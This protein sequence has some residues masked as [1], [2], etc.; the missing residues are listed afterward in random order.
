MINRALKKDL[1]RQQVLEFVN[2]SLKTLNDNQAKALD[3][4]MVELNE[5]ASN[6]RK[7]YFREGSTLNKYQ[8]DLPYIQKT[9]GDYISG[10]K[11]IAS[12]A[13]KM[14][15]D[16][17]HENSYSTLSLAD[18]ATIL[19]SI[20]QLSKEDSNYLLKDVLE[21]DTAL[22]IHITDNIIADMQSKEVDPT[23]VEYHLRELR[24]VEQINADAKTMLGYDLYSTLD[25][26]RSATLLI[27]MNINDIENATNIDSINHDTSINYTI[28][29]YNPTIIQ[30]QDTIIQH[31]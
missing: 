14:V 12:Q 3:P 5:V 13:D 2:A 7:G 21:K 16:M 18:K 4:I 9:R 22:A 30:T 24:A 26:L 11:L 6:E 23:Q 19:S 17:I 25:T 27:D 29:S 20:K 28:T 31:Q 1:T 10:L 8:Q 15:A